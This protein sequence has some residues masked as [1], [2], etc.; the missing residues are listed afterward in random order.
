M[1]R[2]LGVKTMDAPAAV[3]GLRDPHIQ[4][5][6][7]FNAIDLGNGNVIAL[8]PACFATAVESVLGQLSSALASG[9][10]GVNW[11]SV[12]WNSVNWNSVNWNSVNWNS[13]NW[14]SVNWNSVNWNS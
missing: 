10:G 4:P 5:G 2:G 12:N 3:T 8:C 1:P 13:V 9:E 14:N 11:N 6:Q 7:D